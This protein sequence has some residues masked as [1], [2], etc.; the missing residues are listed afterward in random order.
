MSYVQSA[1]VTDRLLYLLTGLFTYTQQS[2]SAAA[3]STDDIDS[4]IN[5]LLLKQTVRS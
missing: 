2:R 3:Q 1:I 4:L 5:A